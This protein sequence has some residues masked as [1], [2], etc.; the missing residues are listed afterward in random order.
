M[1]CS[2]KRDIHLEVR[3]QAREGCEQ[4]RAE[5]NKGSG[6]WREAGNVFLGRILNTVRSGEQE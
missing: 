6:V 3:K 2:D 1:G 5:V 4:Q